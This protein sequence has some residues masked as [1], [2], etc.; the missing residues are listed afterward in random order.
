MEYS[1]NWHLLSSDTDEII[2]FLDKRNAKK[3]VIYSCTSSY[4]AKIED[5]LLDILNIKKNMEN[6]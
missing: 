2:D 5:K 6:L 1:S 3:T 4:P